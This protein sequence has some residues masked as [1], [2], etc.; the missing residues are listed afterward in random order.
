MREKGSDSGTGTLQC[1]VPTASSNLIELV[2]ENGL[3]GQEEIA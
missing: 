2:T 3:L 1:P